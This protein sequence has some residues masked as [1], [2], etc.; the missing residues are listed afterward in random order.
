LSLCPTC[1]A[2][3]S[4]GEQFCPRDG[5][6]LRAALPEDPLSG[7]VLSGRYRLTEVLGRGGMGA[8]YRAH[9]ILMDKPVAVKVLRQ[10]LASDTEAVA[11][12]HRE[13]R[14]ASRLDHDHIIRVT[15]F[16]QTDDG[17]LF[18][19]MELLDGENLAQV[20]RR[21][22]LPW[23]RAATIARD[24]ALGLAHAHEQGV[25]HRDLKPEN[26]V[27][28]RRG[29]SARQLVK[30]LDFGLAKLIHD[31][32]DAGA[33]AAE[34][35]A[36]EE[37][38][39]R[40]LTRTGAI[41]GTPEYM[42]PEQA[43][44][45]GLG[46]R[47]DLYALGVV[48]YQ[49]VS[50]AL[51]F[52]APTFLALIAKT[53]NEPAPPPSQQNASVEIPEAFEAMIMQCLAKE[54]AE[55]PTSAEEIAEA[56]DQ[57]L[58]AY[59]DDPKQSAEG[60]A[61]T[62][63]LVRGVAGAGPPPS[64]RGL[65]GTGPPPSAKGG[66]AGEPV[67]GVAKTVQRNLT[68]GQV[69]YGAGPASAV[70]TAYAAVLGDSARGSGRPP[71]G[72]AGAE[73]RS[74]D[75]GPPPAV[76]VLD[77]DAVTLEPRQSEGLPRS[78]AVSATRSAA[79]AT[80]EPK[81]SGGLPRSGQ[82]AAARSPLP[83]DGPEPAAAAADLAAARPDGEPG[84]ASGAEEEP[85]TV[86]RRPYWLVALAVAAALGGVAYL[87]VPRW[88]GRAPVVTTS[89]DSDEL[90]KARE[91]L[92]PAQIGN[93]G[94]VDE[95][96]G[97]LQ[98]QR[99]SHNSPELQ[100]LLSAAYEAQSNRLR[101]LGH[102]QLAVRLAGSSTEGPRSQLALAQLLARLGHA[103]EAC[104]AALRVLHERPQANPDLRQHAG[105]LATTLNCPGR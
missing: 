36:A 9:H 77:P 35:E 90:R 104:Q 68:P 12:F 61:L 31:V 82:A 84:A 1:K 54:P 6:P 29:K 88:L 63:T 81:Q 55:R 52:S 51:P 59:P 73:R 87:V 17:L 14:S 48:A 10:E 45:R 85:L 92:S 24:V 41:F 94:A 99:Q 74:A 27:L 39:A 38:A 64:A 37:L 42:S 40:S 8:V 69:P 47:T 13:A 30:V 50:G 96:M 3:F 25:I 18:L 32:G 22:P 105:A 101:A 33:E 49:M 98:V 93:P 20:L 7:R 83:A 26:I 70:A 19:V 86:P 23:R 53:V 34:D 15:D 60:G 102:M 46:T 16:G 62:P 56:L 2:S 11:R 79:A 72:A 66:E 89:S 91:L 97:L 100:R 65:L 21:G 95:A 75:P 71:S 103:P 76:R 5:T 58:A 43:E 78:G 57:L 67:G 80:P 44:G 4:G 28:V